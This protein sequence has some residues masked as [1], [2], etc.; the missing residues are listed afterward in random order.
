MQPELEANVLLIT[1][2]RLIIGLRGF[3]I[4]VKTHTTHP[5]KFF[6]KQGEIESENLN[7][8]PRDCVC[9]QIFTECIEHLG[10][11]NETRTQSLPSGS[12]YPS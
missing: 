8:S 11:C 1:P 5:N 10:N 6:V 7:K 2:R 9:I 3:G 4:F 12:L